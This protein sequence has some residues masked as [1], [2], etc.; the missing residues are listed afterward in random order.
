MKVWTYQIGAGA[1]L[2]LFVALFIGMSTMPDQNV[3]AEDNYPC[4]WEKITSYTSELL[5]HGDRP[6]CISLVTA[7]GTAISCDWQ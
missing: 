6:R 5:C 3:V 4:N 1:M 7:Q 2:L